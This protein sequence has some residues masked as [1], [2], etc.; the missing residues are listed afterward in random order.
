VRPQAVIGMKMNK[1]QILMHVEDIF[2]LFDGKPKLMGYYQTLKVEAESPAQA[3]L[4][5]VEKI[6]NDEEIKAIWI[7]ERQKTSPRITAEE[8][9]AVDEFDEEIRRDMTGRTFYPVKQWWQ[10]WK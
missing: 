7:Q 1:Y 10:F 6:R 4:Q 9:N 5:A 2:L 8:I 3:E